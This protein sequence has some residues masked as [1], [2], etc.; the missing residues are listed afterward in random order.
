MKVWRFY[1]SAQSHSKPG[2]EANHP[3]AGSRVGL[4]QKIFEITTWI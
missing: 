3:F 1:V 2:R 4:A